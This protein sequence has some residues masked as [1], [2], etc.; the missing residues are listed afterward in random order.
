MK[1]IKIKD[2][3]LLIKLT[4]KQKEEI[5]KSAALKNQTMS[6]YVLECTLNPASDPGTLELLKTLK[7]H[8]TDVRKFQSQQQ[9]TMYIIMQF[10]MWLNVENH[11]REEIMEFYDEQLKKASERFDKGD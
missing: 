11:S 3:Q 2:E 7:S 5:R 8:F 9:I 4:A 10:V 6:A 1:K